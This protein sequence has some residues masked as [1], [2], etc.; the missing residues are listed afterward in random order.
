MKT[1]KNSTD[2]N[3]FTMIPKSTLN[4][5]KQMLFSSD[6]GIDLS[7]IVNDLT[8]GLQ[9]DEDIVAINTALAYKGFKPEI[10]ETI[11]YEANWRTLN[12]YICISSSVILGL[13]KCKVESFVYNKESDSFV[14]DKYH[15]NS[16]MM[17]DL[18]MWDSLSSD[19]SIAKDKVKKNT[20]GE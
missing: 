18:Q 10:T 4:C 19:D 2:S 12:K 15:E 11:K 9:F 1:V 7:N 20:T 3:G 14:D 17:F 13:V 6:S 5:I 16:M 8:N